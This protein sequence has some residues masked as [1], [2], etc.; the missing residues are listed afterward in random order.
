MKPELPGLS[1]AEDGVFGRLGDTEFYNFLGR[2]LNGR[3]GGRVAA[4][5]GFAVD[6]DE[7]AN[8][9]QRKGVLGVFVGQGRQRVED[10][11]A[12]LLG[13]PALLRQFRGQL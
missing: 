9:R 10:F 8:A 2:N 13:Q 11:S 5:A 6:K 12:G 4:D 7:L 1:G 3:A